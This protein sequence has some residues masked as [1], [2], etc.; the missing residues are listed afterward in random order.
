MEVTPLT[1]TE[2]TGMIAEWL[3]SPNCS[4]LCGTNQV[5]SV[6]TRPVTDRLASTRH[7]TGMHANKLLYTVS[8]AFIT[9]TGML[10]A[11]VSHLLASPLPMALALLGLIGQ[12]VALF[13]ALRQYDQHFAE[14]AM[15]RAVRN[16]E[17]AEADELALLLDHEVKQTGS[18]LRAC[19]ERRIR[20]AKLRRRVTPADSSEW[21]ISPT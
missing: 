18:R 7:Y 9:S 12:G 16:S 21:P 13:L 3:G 4:P 19:D 11:W 15:L 2:R 14:S 8:F 1:P 17:R 5:V 20:E 6:D 10:G